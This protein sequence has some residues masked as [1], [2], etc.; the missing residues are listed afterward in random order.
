MRM[1]ICVIH[2]IQICLLYT[3]EAA[4]DL[5][6]EDLDG[7]LFILKKMVTDLEQGLQ[8]CSVTRWLQMAG[9]PMILT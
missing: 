7:R 4:H 2:V 3:S 9:F 8:Q 1:R 5:L 6:W